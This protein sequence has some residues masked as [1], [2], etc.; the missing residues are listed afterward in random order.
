MA[1]TFEERSN[2][3]LICSGYVRLKCDEISEKYNVSL[4]FP[5]V[6]LLIIIDYFTNPFEW[7]SERR[8]QH[9]I[10]SDDKLTVNNEQGGNGA[11]FAKNLLSSNALKA[12]NWE[13]TA[14]TLKGASCFSMGYVKYDMI[15]SVPFGGW[16]WI[17]DREGQW[18]MSVQAGAAV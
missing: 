3:E 15:Q 18:S 14:K 7:D 12:A 2:P 5:S 16:P 1:A 6:I 9:V 4:T 11:I 13:I 10:V 8:D 17:G